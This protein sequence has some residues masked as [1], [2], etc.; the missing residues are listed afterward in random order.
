[1]SHIDIG[2]YLVTLAPYDK[3]VYAALSSVVTKGKKGGGKDAKPEAKQ[4]LEEFEAGAYTRSHF[5][6]T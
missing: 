6:S 2:S 4:A 1:M 5:R 3:E